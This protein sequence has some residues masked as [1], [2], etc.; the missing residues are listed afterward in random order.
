MS[1]RYA[2]IILAA[3]RG[4]RLLS[5]T[6]EKPKCLV[7]LAGKPL[8]HWQLEA[9][10]ESGIE[11]V[12]VIRGYKKER[13]QGDF[14]TL[15]NPNW[16][17]TNMVSTL[18]AADE[19]LSSGPA[20]VSYSDIVY[21]PAHLTA[22]RETEGDIA[23]CYDQNWAALWSLRFADP[24]GDA[25]TFRV[26]GSVVTEIGGKTDTVTD[27]QGQYMGLLKFTPQGWATV[28]EFLSDLGEHETARLD[29][30]GMLSRLIKAGVTINGCPV[31][32]GWVEVDHPEDIRLYEEKLDQGRAWP[33]NW[34]TR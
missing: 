6:D 27:I 32:G 33:H 26:T 3:G 9:F 1:N 30:T 28:R 20:L 31:D 4:S 10:R 15:E 24:L 23:I 16:Q 34:Q 29:M 25:E 12:T 14:N 7:E 22:L 5:L 17:N 13:L 11:N 21:S 8:L 18:M 19:L 2:G